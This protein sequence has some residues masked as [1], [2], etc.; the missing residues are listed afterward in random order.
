M[1]ERLQR[2]CVSRKTA[3]ALGICGFEL[4]HPAGEPLPA[5]AAGAH[6]DVHVPDGP[7]RQYSLCNP[8]A[9]THRYLIAVQLEAASRGGSAGMH[10]R[11]HEGS[12]LDVSRP[13]N[14]FGLAASA[15]R[16]L[17]LAGGIGVTPM[18]SMAEALHAAEAD[19]ELHYCARSRERMAFIERVSAAPWAGRAQLHF[20]DGAAGQ[21]I[22]LPALLARAEP[23]RHLYVCGP[24]G[25]LD[26]ALS[27]A[28]GRGWTESSLHWESFAAP[29]L[30]PSGDRDFDVLLARSSR[31]VRIPAG[32]SVV[33]ALSDAGVF[34][35][36]SCEQGI[37][38]TCLDAG[39][40][41]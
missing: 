21:R 30:D 16:H 2:L 25:F 1:T 3:R 13:K 41:R 20:D 14:H 35:A 18:L 12:L 33:R 29:P 23:G 7:V 39:A 37:C 5:F 32:S 19:F 17:L 24:R 28:R 36:T 4:V 38:G 11:V 31:V 26:A 40:R 10:E 9:E 6:V 27:V 8:P 34:V 15:R 22:D